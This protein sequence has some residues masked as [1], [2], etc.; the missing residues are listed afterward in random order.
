MSCEDCEAKMKAL[1]GSEL[2]PFYVINAEEEPAGVI[3]QVFNLVIDWNNFMCL[4]G[5]FME[6]E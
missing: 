1:D 3:K 5:I 4:V 6:A 2:W